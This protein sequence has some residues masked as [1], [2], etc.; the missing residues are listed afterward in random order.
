MW[1][2]TSQVSAEAKASLEV[3]KAGLAATLK[4]EVLDAVE[5]RLAV[6][7]ASRAAAEDRLAQLGEALEAKGPS[8]NELDQKFKSLQAQVTLHD[9]N[10]IQHPSQSI[11]AEC[12]CKYVYSGVYKVT[13]TRFTHKTENLKLNL[14]VC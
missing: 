9:T 5:P 7:E 8:T 14:L 13:Q 11:S 6:C 4:Q 1:Q 2:A 3:A 10:I 12:V